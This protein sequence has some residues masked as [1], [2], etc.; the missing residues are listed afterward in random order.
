MKVAIILLSAVSLAAAAP[1]ALAQNS[2]S[3]KTPGHEMQTKGAKVGSPGASSY[4]PGHEMQAKG[5]KNGSPGASGYAPG[6]TTGSA[7]SPG[8]GSTK[9]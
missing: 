9:R 7:S 2:T 3:T 8:S 1:A 6:Q 4:S 5:S